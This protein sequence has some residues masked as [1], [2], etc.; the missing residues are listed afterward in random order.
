[1]GRAFHCIPLCNAG[2]ALIV[3]KIKIN[4]AGTETIVYSSQIVDQPVFDRMT[5][6]ADKQAF[7]G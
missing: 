2:C 3:Q 7:Q 6:S 1:M 5:E 4:F